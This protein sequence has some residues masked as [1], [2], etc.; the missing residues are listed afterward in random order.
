[1]NEL[2]LDKLMIDMNNVEKKTDSN[3]GK[4]CRVISCIHCIG[5][6]CT[7]ETCEIYERTFI[8]EG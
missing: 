1:M 8:Q 6:R 5:D 3:I 2:A 7:N 4:K